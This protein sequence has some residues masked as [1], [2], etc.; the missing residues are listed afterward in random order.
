[1][2]FPP[3]VGFLLYADFLA[4]AA[5]PAE[6]QCARQEGFFSSRSDYPDVLTLPVVELSF[7]E[8]AGNAYPFGAMVTT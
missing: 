7:L 3:Y 2:S 5:I 6:S 4:E 8:F 1:M